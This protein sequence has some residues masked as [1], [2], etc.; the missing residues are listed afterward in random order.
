MKERGF[1]DEE[2]GENYTDTLRRDRE[3]E[4]HEEKGVEMVI[5]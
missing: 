4:M 1:S 5:R 2:I 3:E